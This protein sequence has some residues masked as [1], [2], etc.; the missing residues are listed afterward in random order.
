M[1]KLIVLVIFL[2]SFLVFSCNKQPKVIYIQPLGNVSQ[3]YI[4]VAKKA[5]KSFYGYD[6]IEKKKIEVTTD[7]LSKITKRVEANKL[8][9]KYKS[10]QNTLI[11]TEK[12]ICHFKDKLRPDYGIFGLGLRPGNICVVSTFRLLK[13]VSKQKT[14]ERLSKVALHEI[15]H[16]LGLPHCTYHKECMMN[17]ANGTIQQIDNEKVWFCA[18]CMKQIKN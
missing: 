1:K 16:N 5:V 2:L 18:K 9:S 3:K 7:I 11:L 6:C 4:D 12:D 14:Y 10:S 13:N 8:L 17:D 15:G